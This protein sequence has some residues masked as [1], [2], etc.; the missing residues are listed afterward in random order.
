[1]E[2]SPAWKAIRFSA[3]QEIP[4]ILLKPEVDYRVYKNPPPIPVLSQIN[5]VHATH[6]QISCP[7]SIA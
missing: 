7:F 6:P 3:S 1:M 5:L 2:Q 4:H